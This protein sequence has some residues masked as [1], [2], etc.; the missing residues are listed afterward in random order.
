MN[1]SKSPEFKN[2]SGLSGEHKLWRTSSEKERELEKR[3]D[4][5]DEQKL[6]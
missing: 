6:Y 4:Q 3:K 2:D 1:V 5:E